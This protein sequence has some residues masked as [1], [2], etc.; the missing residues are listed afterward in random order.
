MK[1]PVAMAWALMQSGFSRWLV[2]IMAGVPG[3]RAGFLAITIVTFIILGG[4][5]EGIPAILLC[6]PLLLPPTA[7]SPA[8]DH[9]LQLSAILQQTSQ[10]LPRMA[11]ATSLNVCP[12][13]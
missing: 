6:G 1:I 12:Q 11:S 9:P 2:S 10:F 8:A 3:E 7:I 5:L 13:L 4:V